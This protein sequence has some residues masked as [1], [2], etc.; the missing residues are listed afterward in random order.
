MNRSLSPA[1]CVSIAALLALIGTACS[2]PLESTMEPRFPSGA[3][4]EAIAECQARAQRDVAM[5]R[6][7]LDAGL[8]ATVAGAALASVAVG[9]GAGNKDDKDRKG[10]ALGLGAA[11]V[12]AFA[13]GVV[14][15]HTATLQAD[16]V[17]IACKNAGNPAEK[18]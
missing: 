13:E 14:V 12:F 2:V 15:W 4:D 8:A 5:L 18:K 6:R 17:K 16:E 10:M 11:G 3:Q 1:P 9:L 7:R